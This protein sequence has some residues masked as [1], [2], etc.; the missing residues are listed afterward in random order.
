MGTACVRD[1]V[2]LILLYRALLADE[3]VSDSDKTFY[4]EELA[5]ELGKL[6][7]Q[8]KREGDGTMV[9]NGSL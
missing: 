3:G 2:C 8:M 9:N 1:R 5:E 4:N 6:P 7:E